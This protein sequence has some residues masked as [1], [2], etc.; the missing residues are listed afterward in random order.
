MLDF[1][2]RCTEAARWRRPTFL[3]E[4]RSRTTRE[5]AIESVRLVSE[6]AARRH[7]SLARAV[8]LT[9]VT[10]RFHA[11]RACR[12]FA[13]AAAAA[14]S[15]RPAAARPRVHVQC[16]VVRATSRAPLDD[17]R[18]LHGRGHRTAAAEPAAADDASRAWCAAR[19]DGVDPREVAWLAL[20]EWAALGLYRWRGWL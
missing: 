19:R 9:V 18:P 10:N 2:R 7:R 8:V 20:R 5:N 3:L 12:T 16:A 14:A 1:A 15:G 6:R 11:P 17:A 13:N 4:N